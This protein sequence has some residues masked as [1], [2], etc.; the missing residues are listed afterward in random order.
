MEVFGTG[1]DMRDLTILKGFLLKHKGQ[2]IF[3]LITL[4]VSNLSAL[5]VP[6]ILRDAIDGLKSG[7][8]GDALVRYALLM[9]FLT[10]VAGVFRF[11]T[12]YRL[13]G[14]SFT[15]AYE[16]RNRLFGHL[17]GLSASYFKKTRTGDIM[18]RATNDLEAVRRLLGPGVLNLLNIL[19]MGPMAVGLMVGIS[20]RLTLYAVLPLPFLTISIAVVR[21]KIFS[22]FQQVQEQFSSLSAKAQENLTGIRVIK[23]FA[24]E[25]NEINSFRQ[26]NQGYLERNMGLVKIWGL[27]WPFIMFIAGL[28]MVVV[29]WFGG[30]QV[31]AGAISLGQF[32]QFANYLMMITWPMM[33]LGWVINLLQRGSASMK[34]IGEILNQAPEIKD[35][36]GRKNIQ[37][38]K[39]TIE[40]RNVSFGYDGKQVLKEI[41]L[42]IEKGMTVA[43]VGPTG[44][45]KSTLVSLI[46]RLF[47]PTE[48]EVVIDGTDVKQIPIKALRKSIGYAPQESFLFSESIKENIAYGLEDDDVRLVQEAATVSNLTDDIEGF[49]QGYDTVVGE[50]GVML[51]GGQ[52]QRVALARAI[53]RHPSI[54]ILD[55]VFSSVDTYTEEEILKRLRRFMQTRTSILISH[56]IST[57]READL[58]VVLKDG[59]IVEQG[60]HEQLLARGGFYANMYQQQQVL[61]EIARM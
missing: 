57:V 3:G 32:V 44:A 47:D 24:Q 49:P 60:T 5:L 15:I 61:E 45:G 14:A 9:V 2:F 33:A 30:R 34:R 40:F 55:D 41:N 16:L 42:K 11:L 37:T 56:R 48:G 4:I 54:L 50:R 35:N 21:P 22:R 19:I 25:E 58:I 29:L 38:L 26:I 7:M 18:A 43:I 10:I 20:P 12:R 31:I 1:N 8:G 53:A 46:P 23:A 27:F 6:R 36:K 28:S 52:K 59:Q 13:I 17:Q 51:S 39:G